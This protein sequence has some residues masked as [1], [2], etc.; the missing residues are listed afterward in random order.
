MFSAHN[1]IELEINKNLLKIT[2][3]FKYL[4]T[5]NT[6]LNNHESKKS[7]GKLKKIFELNEN[8]DTIYHY[9]W[10]KIKAVPRRKFVTMNA[11]IRKQ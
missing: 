10:E 1:N 5:N 11:Y 6:L 8:K 2:I 9:L 3:I 4:E 7:Q